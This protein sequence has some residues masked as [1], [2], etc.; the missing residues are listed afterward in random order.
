MLKHLEKH[1]PLISILFTLAILASL[2]FLPGAT[3]LL[4]LLVMGLGILAILTFTVRRHVQAHR[5]GESRV[6]L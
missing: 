1:W 6:R 5:Q 2:F 3:R 4:S